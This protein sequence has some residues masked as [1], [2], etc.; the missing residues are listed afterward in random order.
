[1]NPTE[2]DL[3]THTV[4]QFVADFF[5][6]RAEGIDYSEFRPAP[7]WNGYIAWIAEAGSLLEDVVQEAKKNGGEVAEWYDILEES[8]EA[9]RVEL[10]IK[11]DPVP[12]NTAPCS[13]TLYSR[14]CVGDGRD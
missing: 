2:L 10:V 14:Y 13:E 6:N 1:V 5:G 4:A 11:T 9:L 3:R 8:T 7:C 12:S